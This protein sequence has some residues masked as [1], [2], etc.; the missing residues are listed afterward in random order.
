M[1]LL[2]Q[3]TAKRGVIVSKFRRGLIASPRLKMGIIGYAKQGVAGAGVDKYYDH[4]QMSASASWT[5]N[6]NLSK[7]PS[8]TTVD[9]SGGVVEG[10]ITHV[11]VNQLTIS[12]TSAF[13][14]HAY[15]N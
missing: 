1:A 14:G 7:Y 5:V 10:Y 15:C 13:A 8:V 2:L 9:S 6:H 11:S 4:D 3:T 12:F